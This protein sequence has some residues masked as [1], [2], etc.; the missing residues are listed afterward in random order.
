MPIREVIRWILDRVIIAFSV[1]I[2][3]SNG[4]Y[5]GI[6]LTNKSL[7]YNFEVF[8]IMTTILGGLTFLIIPRRKSKTSNK[9]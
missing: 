1:A 9:K 2:L 4:P 7:L 3:V 6:E 5:F 8:L